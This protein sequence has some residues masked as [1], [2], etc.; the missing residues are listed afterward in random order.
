[1][2]QVRVA[3]VGHSGAGKSTFV[4]ITR[5]YCA[6]RHLT[7]AR[8]GLAEPLYE[9]QQAFRRAAGQDYDATR[10]D[11]VLLEVIAAQL[12]RLDPHALARPFLKKVKDSDADLVI[13]DDLRDVEVDQRALVHEGFTLVRVVA[14]AE[15]RAQRRRLRGDVSSSDESSRHVEGIVC[16]YT[17]DNCSGLGEYESAVRNLLER[18]LDFER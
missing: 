13:N 8:I 4:A 3:V 9:L 16:R 15:L 18:I 7:V 10:Q 14:P 5:R 12:R 1:M 6:E 11:Q 17:I 2:S